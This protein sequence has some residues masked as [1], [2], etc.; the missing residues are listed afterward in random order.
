MDLGMNTMTG[1]RIRRVR[2]Y[3][4]EGPF[5]MT[6]GDGMCDVDI[7]KLLEFHKAYGKLAA[8]TD[9]LM[10]QQIFDFINGINS[11]FEKDVLPVLAERGELM[12]YIHIG[13]WQCMDTKREKIS[14][15]KCGIGDCTVEGVGV[16][17]TFTHTNQ[18]IVPKIVHIR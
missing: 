8:L 2:S 1:G 6:Y 3:L 4:G 9:V 11:I 10:E 15:R 17:G 16:K 18:P 5:L 14:W 7:S 13:F 12:F